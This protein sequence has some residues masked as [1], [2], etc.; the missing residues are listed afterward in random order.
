MKAY[1]RYIPDLDAALAL[2]EGL[3]EDVFLD[4][5]WNDSAPICPHCG[6]GRANLLIGIE[7]RVLLKCYWCRKQFSPFTKTPLHGTHMSAKKWLIV[8]ASVLQSGGKV[9]QRELS[10]LTGCGIGKCHSLK[11]RAIA[12]L[13]REALPD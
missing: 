5:R 6:G 3:A 12:F 9:K 11:K 4:V 8:L 7:S 10:A 13:A 1:T 2:E